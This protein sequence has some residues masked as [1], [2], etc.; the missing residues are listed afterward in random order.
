MAD[1]GSG[2]YGNGQARWRICGATWILSTE[3][4]EGGDGIS[5]DTVILQNICETAEMAFF[6]TFKIEYMHHGKDYRGRD[7]GTTGR[8]DEVDIIISRYMVIQQG[9]TPTLLYPSSNR[10]SLPIESI[11]R[12]HWYAGSLRW[13]QILKTVSC[14]VER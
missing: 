13:F 6:W 5:S 11:G 9:T 7:A 1:K 2:E 14:M 12:W 8:Q 3:T 10:R 4:R